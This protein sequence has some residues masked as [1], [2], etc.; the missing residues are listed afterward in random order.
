M[1]QFSDV[2][3]SVLSLSKHVR[4]YTLN[5]SASFIDF[6]SALNDVMTSASCYGLN[7]EPPTPNSYI[8]ALTLKTS[9]C[10][11]IWK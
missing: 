7:C 6:Q 8:E 1:R 4:G 9:K 10:D 2:C 5:S 3:T 11:C